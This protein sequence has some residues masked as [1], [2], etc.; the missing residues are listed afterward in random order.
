MAYFV[1]QSP[2]R[3]TLK[4]KALKKGDGKDLKDLKDQRDGRRDHR[5]LSVPGGVV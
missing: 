1:P 3:A 5:P 4:M 2:L